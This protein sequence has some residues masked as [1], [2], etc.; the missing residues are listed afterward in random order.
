MIFLFF[1]N[2]QIFGM[3]DLE[4]IISKK[5]VKQILLPF[6]RN[7][8]PKNMLRL[9]V[10]LA[11]ILLEKNHWRPKKQHPLPE[12][13]SSPLK[14]LVSNKNIPT[15][16]APPIFRDQICSFQGG[17]HHFRPQ[18]T[19]HSTCGRPF[20]DRW[21]LLLLRLEE[22]DLQQAEPG[23]NRSTMRVSPT[24]ETTEPFFFGGGMEMF[25]NQV[26]NYF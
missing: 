26:S 12:T 15:F 21:P 16:Q 25:K 1:S 2:F 4:R 5:N 24:G 18:K 19:T 3:Q 22:V 20:T 7:R 14:M 6:T 11:Q 8:T 13:N 23:K 10:Q 17:E 9:L